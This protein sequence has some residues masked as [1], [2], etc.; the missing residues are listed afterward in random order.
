MK[1]YKIDSFNSFELFQQIGSTDA[2]SKIMSKKT[3]S[4]LLYIKNIHVGAAN[5]LKQ[6]AL[7]IGA[8]LCVPMGAIL[9]TDKFVDTILLGTT[10]QFEQLSKKE[11][12]QPFGLKKLAKE[13]KSFVKLHNNESVKIMGIINANDDSFFSESRYR[14]KKAVN[15]IL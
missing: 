12:T 5:I 15:K 9:A 8:D 2:G 7:S 14:G 1:F 13:L 10:K 11:L 6:D 3:K 4:H